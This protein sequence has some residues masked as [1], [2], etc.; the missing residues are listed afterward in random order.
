MVT[1]FTPFAVAGVTVNTNVVVVVPLLGLTE[2]ATL[3]GGATVT[4]VE[5]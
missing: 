5:V 2:M 4:A 1:S 3:G